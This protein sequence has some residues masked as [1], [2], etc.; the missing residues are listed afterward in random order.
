MANPPPVP[1][2]IVGSWCKPHW[3]CDHE[4]VYGPEG[5]WWRVAEQHRAEALDDAVLLAIQDQ[6]RAGLSLIGDGEQ[7]R[8]T[9]SGHFYGL[10]GIDQDHQGAVTN[11]NND[12]G[13][14]LTMKARAAATGDEAPAPPKFEQPRVTGPI[15]WEGPI[16]GGAAEFLL[17]NTSGPT[18]MTVIGPNTLALRLVDE[19]YGSLAAL[20]AALADVLNKEC[21]ALADMGIDLVQIDEPEVHFRYSQ[22]EP[23]AADAIDRC[24]HGVNAATAVHMCYGYSKNIAEKRATPVYEKAVSLL[25]STTADQLSLEYEQ[26]GHQP[27]LLTHAGDK[28]VILGVL[29][30]DTEAPVETADHIVERARDAAT[31]IGLDRLSLAPDCGMWFLPRT[32]ALGK[33]TA[34]ESAARTLRGTAT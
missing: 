25:A 10:G 16:L 14:Y 3:L 12:V 32:T 5:T 22:V 34:M 4:L 33:I 2:Q 29:N 26:P 15:T 30:L 24:L 8:Q 18:K 6:A 11:F 28:G 13:D 19:H 20:A 17:A 1:T 7:R 31:V 23:F 21:R 9:F 27:E